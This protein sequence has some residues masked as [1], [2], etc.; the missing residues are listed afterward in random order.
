MD[1]S[2]VAVGTVMSMITDSLTCRPQKSPAGAGRRCRSWCRASWPAQGPS[3]LANSDELAGNLDDP[4]MRIFDATVH[5]RLKESGGLYWVS[6][7]ADYDSAHIP[8]A[9][10]LDILETSSDAGQTLPFM[11]PDEAGLFF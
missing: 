2:Y 8:G 9:A 4:R 1:T 5:V 11:L 7:R 3:G 10:F 6:G